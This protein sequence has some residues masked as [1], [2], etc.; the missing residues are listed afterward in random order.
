MYA[1]N[2]SRQQINQISNATLAAVAALWICFCCL[3][4]AASS[5]ACQGSA[6]W[7]WWV[8][9]GIS[10]PGTCCSLLFFVVPAD[11]WL[12]AV[13]TVHCACA[14]LR[15]CLEERR[16]CSLKLSS[17]S[18]YQR[19]VRVAIQLIRQHAAGRWHAARKNALLASGSMPAIPCVASG[20]TDGNTDIT[21]GQRSHCS[22]QM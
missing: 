6:I 19:P 16:V 2:K 13:V 9:H 8:T 3:M 11:I 12:A 5:G 21:A 22:H 15:G 1:L 14:R 10:G 7:H 17:E 4:R 18:K 20:N